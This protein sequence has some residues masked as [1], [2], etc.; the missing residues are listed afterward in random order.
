MLNPCIDEAEEILIPQ[1]TQYSSQLLQISVTKSQSKDT[2]NK[3]P[4]AVTVDDK[5]NEVPDAADVS[6]YHI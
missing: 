3:E 4:T 5:T 1:V 2:S 6:N